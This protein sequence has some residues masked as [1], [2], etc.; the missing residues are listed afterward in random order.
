MSSGNHSYHDY[1]PY[2][3][4]LQTLIC[5]AGLSI[6]TQHRLLNG[7]RRQVSAELGLSEQDIETVMSVQADT[8]QTFAQALDASAA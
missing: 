4:H 8:M 5:N 2:N 1:D 6:D 3:S 7:Q